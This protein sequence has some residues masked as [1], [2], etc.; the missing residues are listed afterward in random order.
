MDHIGRKY[1][2]TGD[3]LDSLCLYFWPLLRFPLLIND[4]YKP[5]IVYMSSYSDEQHSSTF[6]NFLK[7]NFSTDKS[8]SVYCVCVCVCVIGGGEGSEACAGVG[9]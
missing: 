1:T 4:L 2:N 5:N 9:G 6:F 7:Q 3:T 8:F